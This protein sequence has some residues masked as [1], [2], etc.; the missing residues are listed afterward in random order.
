M[1]VVDKLVLDGTIPTCI[2]ML[3]RDV[4]AFRSEIN[5]ATQTDNGKRKST[6]KNT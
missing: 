2:F 1:N 3:A 5:V 6:N 4:M